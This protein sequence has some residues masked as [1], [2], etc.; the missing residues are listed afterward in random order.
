M[1]AK[2]S[3]AYMLEI[4]STGPE[5]HP[6]SPVAGAAGGAGLQC[7]ALSPR[8]RGSWRRMKTKIDT[9]PKPQ[10]FEAKTSISNAWCA[11]PAGIALLGRGTRARW[12]FGL[13][14]GPYPLHEIVQAPNSHFF[15]MYGYCTSGGWDS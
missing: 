12:G 7:V 4:E 1:N 8:G 6:L 11:Q 2:E 15:V 3:S 13:P 14:L 10:Q 9:R 5:G